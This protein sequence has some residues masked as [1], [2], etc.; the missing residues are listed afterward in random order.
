MKYITINNFIEEKFAKNLIDEANKIINFDKELIIHKN[1]AFLSS[2]SINF[3]KLIKKSSSWKLLEEKINSQNF[4]NFCLDKLKEDK[5]KYCLKNFFKKKNLNKYDI[6]FKKISE[7]KIKSLSTFTLIKFTLF[8]LY[9]NCLR[10]FKFS[11]IF[12]PTK[13]PLELLFDFSRA[14]NGYINNIHRDS[15]SRVVVFLLYLNSLQKKESSR[16]GDLHFHRLIKQNENS[17]NPNLDSYEIIDTVK[18]EPGKLV[19]FLNED[20]TFHSVNKMENFDG[21]R[22]FL[23]GGFTILSGK[24]SN[25]N[26]SKSNTEFYLYD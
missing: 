15:D 12:Y 16:G 11:K 22:Y 6:S 1:R 3:N 13:Q 4:L 9:Q 25:I 21:Y 19:I 14:G 18:P 24:N 17:S 23:Y 7:K 2:T 10:T 8:R 5:S 20:E 26:N